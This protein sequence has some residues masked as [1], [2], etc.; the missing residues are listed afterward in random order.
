MNYIFI[1]GAREPITENT[2]KVYDVEKRRMEI[3]EN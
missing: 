3:G 2:M 1:Y